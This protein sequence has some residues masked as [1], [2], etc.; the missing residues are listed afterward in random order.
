MRDEIFR[1][2]V[3]TIL[4]GVV[5]TDAQLPDY[6]IVYCNPG[7][8][9][10][11]GY[12]SEEVLGRNCRFLQGPATNPETVARLRRAIHEGRPA[13]VLL[14]NYRKDGQPFW[15]DLRIA[16]VRDV[17]GRLTHFVGIQSDVS[18]KVEGVRLLEQALEEWRS[19][20][21]TLHHHHHH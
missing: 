13:H 3:E 12:P 20:V 16:P 18:A 15:N 17:E 9:Q 1:I 2:A 11:T 7:F 8:V 21:D 10:L 5:I 19:T 4:A 14:L 6:P